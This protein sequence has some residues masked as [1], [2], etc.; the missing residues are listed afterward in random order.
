VMICLCDV[1]HDVLFAPLVN[2]L[3]RATERTMSTN[4]Q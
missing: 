3:L 4:V 2:V 1:Q